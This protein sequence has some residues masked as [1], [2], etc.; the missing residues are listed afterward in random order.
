MRLGEPR[1]QGPLALGVSAQ[2]GPSSGCSPWRSWNPAPSGA[3]SSGARAALLERCSPAVVGPAGG[4]PAA[5]SCAW[6]P[7]QQQSSVSLSTLNRPHR[8]TPHT[9]PCRED[10]Q[11][12][13]TQRSLL[14]AAAVQQRP[15][16]RLLHATAPPGMATASVS[17]LMSR[18]CQPLLA[19][20]PSSA[21]TLFPNNFF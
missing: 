17:S 2:M 6:L 12:S 9:C 14:P 3:P 5:A 13:H 19:A 7:L 20:L 21:L 10:Q 8:T 11:G 18:Q 16:A 15:P 4:W 1:L